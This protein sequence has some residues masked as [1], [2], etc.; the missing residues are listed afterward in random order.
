MPYLR[1]SPPASSMIV[2]TIS[3]YCPRALVRR[4][5]ILPAQLACK[6]DPTMP[7]KTPT[8]GGTI[9]SPSL[10]SHRRCSSTQWRHRRF[11]RICPGDCD[12]SGE[13]A[14]RNVT[15]Q[16]RRRLFPGAVA[17]VSHTHPNRPNAVAKRRL[18]P[19]WPFLTFD[20]DG[21]DLSLLAMDSIRQLRVGCSRPVVSIANSLDTVQERV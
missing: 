16:I 9:S 12:R 15:F 7:H 13:T 18:V 11:E 21:L 17:S 19:N 8:P 6:C 20:G 4:G 3:Q 5:A 10:G 1:G 2:G 14:A